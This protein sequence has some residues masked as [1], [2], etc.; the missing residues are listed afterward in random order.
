MAAV[1]VRAD[2]TNSVTLGVHFMRTLASAI[3]F[4]LLLAACGSEVEEQASQA[5]AAKT[6]TIGS[7]EIPNI[8]ELPGRVEPIRTAEVRARVTGIVQ[9]R[10][11]EEGTDVGKGQPLFRIDPAELRASLAQTQAS[12]RRAQAT[13]ANAGAVV[14]RYRPLV[15]ENAISQQEFDAAIAASREATAN[16]AQIRA[17]ID[18]A[19]LQLGYTTVRAPIAGRVG[20]AQVTEGALVSQGEGTLMAR[21]E[22]TSPVYVTFAE[23]SSEMMR[24][25]RGIREGTIDLGESERVEVRL[26]FSDGT[27]YP[28]VGE[29]DFLDFSVDRTTG[30]VALR[31]R[32]AN[33]SGLLIPGEFVRAKL[34]VGTRVN[35]IAVPQGAVTVMENGGTVMVLGKDG[36]A[37][38][39]PVQLG[40][41]SG[42]KWII[43]SGLEVGD[44]IIVSN[45]QKIR[46]GMPVKSSNVPT[47]QRG[48][49]PATQ[50]TS[51]ADRN[52]T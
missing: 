20:R 32:F 2:L 50:K 25:R 16:V 43:E 49:A 46:P 11:F 28:V 15:A 27:E 34:Y 1:I 9:Q 18:S 5:I 14:K 17:Q 41:L 19:Q 40:Q 10:L 30:T 48:A 29:I 21:V 45:L 26:T 8:I 24:I 4:S 23:S 47:G 52:P 33:P 7:E 37:A 12:L 38:P 44:T 6:L 13:A 51:A 42:E 35:G 36:K 22:Q 39:R 3:A 31:A